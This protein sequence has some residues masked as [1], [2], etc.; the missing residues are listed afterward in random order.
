M[1]GALE[2]VKVIEFSQIIAAP[3]CGMLLADMGADVIKVE[4]PQGEPWR[5]FAQFIPLESKTFI[6]LNRGK[7]SLPLDMTRPEAQA[8]AHRLIKDAD[9]VLL[10]Y[11]PDVPAKV[12]LDYETLSAL[13]PRLIYC[14]NTA[15]GRRGPDSYR[16]GYDIIIQAMSGLMAAQNKTVNGVPQVPA[17][18]AADF[19][20]AITM[21]WSISA[22]LYAR[23]KTGRGQKIEAALLGSALAIQTS[24]FTNIEA[25]D[26]N[27]M[28]QFLAELNEARARGADWEELA[29]VQENARPMR[30]VGN[31]YY[32]TYKTQDGYIAVGCLSDSL[33]RKMAGAL[34]LRDPRFEDPNWDPMSEAARAAG[35]KLVAEAEALFQTKTTAEWLRVLDA[36]GVP[37]GPV[38]FVEEL[39][40][41]PQVVANDLV[42]TVDHPLAGPVQ[43]VG[44]IVQMS[45]TPMTVD[46]PS[47]ALGQHTRPIL[48]SLGYAE[49]E[50]NRLVAEGVT[51][52][53]ACGE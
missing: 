17:L 13:N 19:A 37:S 20:T 30:T 7:R 33:R 29:G 3:F 34:G 28:P 16:P 53:W 49:E 15:F 5:L 1:G 6:S 36:A 32:R 10:N 9:V 12:K 25:Y 42:T 48:S 40:D 8:I 11:R 23:E 35:E 18:A 47:P 26:V 4:P 31:I 14:E 50:I 45:D 2:G 52:D 41:D 44:K 24:R 22:A 46:H 51:Y 27:W 43:M 21:A 39:F 38:R